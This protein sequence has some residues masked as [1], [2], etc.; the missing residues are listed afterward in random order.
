MGRTEK[1]E[2]HIE[3]QILELEKQS[4]EDSGN[5]LKSNLTPP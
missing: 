2:K 3:K 1:I 5:D 4:C